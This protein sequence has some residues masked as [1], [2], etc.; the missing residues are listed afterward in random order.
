MKKVFALLLCTL[1]CFCLSACSNGGNPGEVS[2]SGAA[3]NSNS[4]SSTK[5]DSSDVVNNSTIDESETGNSNNSST[6]ENSDNTDITANSTISESVPEVPSDSEKSTILV[7]YF[8]LADEQ[9]EV[10]VIEKGNTEIIAEIIAEKTGADLFKITATTEYPTTY[11]G[12][13]DISR[14][15][16]N[17][18]PQLAE[19]VT[20]LVDYD[21]VFIGYP[22]WWGNLPTIVKVFLESHDFSGKTVIPFCTHAG[23]GLSGTQKSVQS[24]CS[25]A[26]VKNG[27]AVRG[28]TAQNDSAASEKAVADWLAE[29]G[30][31]G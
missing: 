28:S 7:A 23:S 15:E 27:L 5:P 2:N 14:K 4:N 11:N 25:G 26:E 30:I 31:N 9:Y 17:A 13:L 21:T 16:E 1:M 10:G 18:P 20:K 19:T 8:S 12:L 6:P 29:L 24:L 22:I 3:A